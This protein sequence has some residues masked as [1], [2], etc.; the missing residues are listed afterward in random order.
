[1]RGQ[2]TLL[3]II[4]ILML[5]VV[6]GLTL[7]GSIAQRPA[8]SVSG[9]GANTVSFEECL[10]SHLSQGALQVAGSGGI[11]AT[12]SQEQALAAAGVGDFFDVG[13][14]TVFV[15]Y[16]LLRPFPA[17]EGILI[18]AKYEAFPGQSFHNIYGLDML[19][20]LNTGQ[21]SIQRVLYDNVN[22]QIRADN[23]C[24]AQNIS[25][26][27]LQISDYAINLEANAKLS[28]Q[29]S[30][31]SYSVKLNAPLGILLK[32]AQSAIEAERTDLYHNFTTDSYPDGIQA[33]LYSNS[34]AGTVKKDDVLALEIPTYTMGGTP[35]VFRTAVQDRFP[36]ITGLSCTGLQ[37]NSIVDPDENDHPKYT[38]VVCNSGT[39]S[40]IT[41]QD[42][43]GDSRVITI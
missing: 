30:S 20:S 33:R 19:P 13:S 36:M 3:V 5:L 34:N 26:L 39:L 21:L 22:S 43:A 1:M 8:P 35:F 40:K 28:S 31:Q 15:K 25:F 14:K 38:D 42:D 4:G 41:L 37:P 23:N 10:Q 12:H 27:N 17:L 16:G 32:A 9:N 24:G 18:N 29:S 2:V 11:I 7:L 6:G